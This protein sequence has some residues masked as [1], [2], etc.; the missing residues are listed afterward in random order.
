MTHHHNIE[1]SM[2]I[3]I[4]LCYFFV[5]FLILL[6]RTKFM[7]HLSL[8]QLLVAPMDLIDISLISIVLFISGVLF[9]SPLKNG[10][11]S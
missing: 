7:R 2:R 4:F 9:I 1:I 3:K 11:L 6:D 10:A 8:I 5:F